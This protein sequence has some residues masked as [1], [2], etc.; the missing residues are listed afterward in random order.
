MVM[1]DE[2]VGLL[3]RVMGQQNMLV[4]VVLQA[5]GQD[6]VVE[7]VVRRGRMVLAQMRLGP[8]VVMQMMGAVGL[9]LLVVRIHQWGEVLRT[10]AVVLVGIQMVLLWWLGLLV[11]VKVAGQVQVVVCG[12]M[13]KS[14]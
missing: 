5:P 14:D 3:L 4:G 9:G 1:Q 6:R 7:V 12:P 8:V 13:G 2:L 11:V 10:V